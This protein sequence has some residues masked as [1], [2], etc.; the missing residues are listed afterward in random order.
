[1]IGYLKKVFLDIL[2]P[3]TAT[4]IGAYIVTNYVAPRQQADAPKV[5]TAAPVA[6]KLVHGAD[7]MAPRDVETV[8]VKPQDTAKA[9]QAA[10]EVKDTKSQEAKTQATKQQDTQQQDAKRN[11]AAKLEKAQAAQSQPAQSQP[12]EAKAAS[13]GLDEKRDAAE[14]ARA[15]LDRLRGNQIPPTHTAAAPQTPAPQPAAQTAA[16]ILT[17]VPAAPAV[18]PAAPVTASAAPSTSAPALAPPVVIIPQREERSVFGERMSPPAEIPGGR[19]MASSEDRS[20]LGGIAGAA[21]SLVDVV[22]PR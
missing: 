18:I 19:A 8:A 20:L 16:V 3:V 13:V 4:V 22:I 1:M 2:P 12:V 7:G 14:M 21:K 10:K 15:A 6:E 17:A 9:K 11:E 5:E